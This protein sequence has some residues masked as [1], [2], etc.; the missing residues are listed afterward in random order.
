[1]APD[2]EY[3][4]NCLARWMLDYW[5]TVEQRR[6]SLSRMDKRHGSEFMQDLRLRIM[7]EHKKQKASR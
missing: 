7:A 4:R 6:A 2:E 1:M 5:Q 3:K